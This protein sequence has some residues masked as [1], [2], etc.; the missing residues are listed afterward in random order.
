M[1]IHTGS[2]SRGLARR[3]LC[4][5]AHPLEAPVTRSA[6]IALPALALLV[7]CP[8]IETPTAPIESSGIRLERGAWTL[9]LSDVELEGR[10]P[11]LDARDFEGARIEGELH[12]TPERAV[13][14]LDGVIMRGAYDGVVLAVEGTLEDAV[15]YE[16][17]LDESHP[18]DGDDTGAD[19]GDDREDE[20]VG[21]PPPG[22]E[23]EDEPGED[24]PGP[25]D[26][27]PEGEDLWVALKAE[28]LA[29]DRFSGV[30]EIE[31]RL[32]GVRCTVIA[33]AEGRYHVDRDE[34]DRP[35]DD[36]PRPGRDEDE[37]VDVGVGEDCPDGEEDC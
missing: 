17:D 34:P 7:A 33:T 4:P 13:L 18:D 32:P 11:E 1:M 12:L 30:L 6:L 36:E 22:V 16:E 8:P 29:V 19:P 3:L 25:G 37:E 35:H 26:D 10:C 14:D 20:G 15:V 2:G 9:T 21:A 5:L 27:E 28:A 31:Y 24:G 23:G